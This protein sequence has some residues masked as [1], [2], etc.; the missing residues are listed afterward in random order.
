MA[1]YP[2]EVIRSTLPLLSSSAVYPCASI[3]V[4]P[5]PMSVVASCS[6]LR[7]PVVVGSMS[8]TSCFHFVPRLPRCG[9]FRRLTTRQWGLL[10]YASISSV[11]HAIAVHISSH[12]SSVYK[13]RAC[14]NAV[15]I[16]LIHDCGSCGIGF[17]SSI[18]LLLSTL[19]VLPFL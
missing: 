3:C 7:C 2:S 6:L 17:S 16:A 18:V 14:S 11:V 19:L 12:W 10:V 9:E 4:I 1:P 5:F 8:C 15:H 13:S